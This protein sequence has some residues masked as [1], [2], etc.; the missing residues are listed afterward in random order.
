MNKIEQAE[1]I[2]ECLNQA[3]TNDPD[4]FNALLKV[5]FA[6]NIHT[7]DHPFLVVGSTSGGGYD[8]GPMGFLNGALGAVGIPRIAAVIEDSGDCPGFCLYRSSTD[9]Q[10]V[11]GKP[12]TL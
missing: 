7:A 3:R 10:P 1:S 2:V 11:H 12:L 9:P 5:C 6:A 4:L 8:M